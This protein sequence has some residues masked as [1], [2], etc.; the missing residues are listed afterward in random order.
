MVKISIAAS[1]GIHRFFRNIRGY[2]ILMIYDI[3]LITDV[4]WLSKNPHINCVRPYHRSTKNSYRICFLV[5]VQQLYRKRDGVHLVRAS[6][7]SLETREERSDLVI[8]SDRQERV[9]ISVN[10]ILIKTESSFIIRST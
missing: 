6:K 10:G 3:F 1:I 4:E 5:I 7:C 2:I 9:S 8:I